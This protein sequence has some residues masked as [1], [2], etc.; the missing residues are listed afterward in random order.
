M[1]FV[2]T[3]IHSVAIFLKQ[4]GGVDS[5][6]IFNGDIRVGGDYD[7]LVVA[8]VTVLCSWCS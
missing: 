6:D 1:S 4:G 7:E 2:I 5:G 3:F 8:M